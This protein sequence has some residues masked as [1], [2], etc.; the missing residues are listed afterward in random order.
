MS[1]Q[2]MPFNT[3]PPQVKTVFDISMIKQKIIEIDN[4]IKKL[5]AEGSENDFNLELKIIDKF[6]DF[7]ATHPFLVK[8]ICKQDDLSTLYVMFD[9]LEKVEKGEKTL[10]G[11]ELNLGTQLANQFLYP[12]IKK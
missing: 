7:Y 11:V 8:K 9:N 5:I 10:A 2:P 4:E 12:N 3:P 6:Q 1:K